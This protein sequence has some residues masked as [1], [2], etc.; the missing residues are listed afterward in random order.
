MIGTYNDLTIGQFLKCKTIAEFE[1]DPLQKNIRM[2]AEISG[3]TAE[4]IE[5]LPI[6]EL[7]KKLKT[8]SEI[9]SLPA[10]SKVKMR[11]KVG[12]KRFECI[13]KT[14][15]LTA[16]QYIDV[17]HFCSDNII[18]NI[19]NILAAICVRRTWGKRGK[20]DGANHKEIADLFYNNMKISQ[21]YPIMVF[22]CKYSKV[23]EDNILAC[24]VKETQEV[25]ALFL[26]NGA[27]LR[28]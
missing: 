14:Q 20:Y 21:A 22:F 3:K 8:L 13:W 7:L 10:D 25:A 19:H 1:T 24:L 18:Q 11:F 6:S 28:S 2:L 9:N 27:G 12:G 17:T 23:L 4:E 15:E 26:K 16:A 5:E